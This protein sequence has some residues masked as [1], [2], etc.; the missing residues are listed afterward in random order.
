MFDIQ[1]SLLIGAEV[2][3]AF[4]ITSLFCSKKKKIYSK[5]AAVNKDHS[6]MEHTPTAAQQRRKR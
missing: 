4:T 3:G 2:E 1:Y 5:P 6:K